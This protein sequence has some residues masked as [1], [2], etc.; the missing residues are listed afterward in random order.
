MQTP[1]YLSEEY[2]IYYSYETTTERTI[3][4]EEETTAEE[5]VYPDANSHPKEELG[6]R[7]ILMLLVLLIVLYLIF[8]TVYSH[9]DDRR[10]CHF[11]G[12]KKRS[13]D[14]KED[15]TN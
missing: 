4:A 15:D 13:K 11:P 6:N 3:G 12:C 5:I 10:R 7:W 9:M 8:G 2:N 1:I 14:H